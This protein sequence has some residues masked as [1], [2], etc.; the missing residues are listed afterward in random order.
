MVTSAAAKSAK[1]RNNETTAQICLSS[2]IYSLRADVEYEAH[3]V[4]ATFPMMSEEEFAGLKEDIRV[5]GQSVPVVM[6]NQN[7]IDGRNRYRACRELGIACMGADITIRQQANISEDVLSDLL[8][9]FALSLN[10]RR[11]NL[12]PGQLAFIA[13]DWANAK[14][15][16]PK[17]GH[18]TRTVAAASLRFSVSERYISSARFINEN[19]ATAVEESPSLAEV[20]EAVKSGSEDL[21]QLF[22]R[23]TKAV[24]AAAFKADPQYRQQRKD[25][26]AR[27]KA[28]REKQKEE[29]ARNPRV[30]T[31]ARALGMMGS[32]H[33]NEVVIAARKVE[34]MRK[35]LGRTWPQLLGVK[36]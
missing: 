8:S 26:R 16:K 35:K 9:D 3:P 11:R 4:A 21:N 7:I 30:A 34:E 23:V 28:E 32:D 33:D 36:S 5:K 1:L 10:L 31:L 22:E 17:A 18:H 14:V 29:Q 25:E 19:L 2:Q 15:G 20:M 6:Y 27:K 13:A 12:T 24:N